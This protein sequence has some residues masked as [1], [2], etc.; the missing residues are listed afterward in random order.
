MNKYIFAATLAISDT[1]GYRY[2]THPMY[3]ESDKTAEEVFNLIKQYKNEIDEDY[4][5]NGKFTNYLIVFPKG[6]ILIMRGYDLR[7]SKVYSLEEWIE[8]VTP[9]WGLDKSQVTHIE[10]K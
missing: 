3:I 9:A 8:H 2:E 5:N 4:K 1:I 7:M 10:S 6:E